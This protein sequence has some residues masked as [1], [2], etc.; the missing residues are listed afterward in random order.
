MLKRNN[1]TQLSIA[2]ILREKNLPVP[3]ELITTET[4]NILHPV[5]GLH[6][7][8][9]APVAVHRIARVAAHYGLYLTQMPANMPVHLLSESEDFLIV[10]H[11]TTGLHTITMCKGIL[12]CPQ[13]DTLHDAWE[14]NG[15]IHSIYLCQPTLSIIDNVNEYYMET[16]L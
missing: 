5:T 10:L 14:L 12:F 3:R 8:D 15:L 16:G 11:L 13:S 7:P 6:A 1:C 9:D 4:V 2:H